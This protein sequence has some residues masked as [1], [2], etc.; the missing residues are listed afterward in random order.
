MAFYKLP[1]PW[2]SNAVLT[3][4]RSSALKNMGRG[5]CIRDATL[6][7]YMDFLECC[8]SVTNLTFHCT[9]YHVIACKHFYRT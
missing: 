4:Q 8:A 6:Y 2:L 9:L 1:V 3:I 7:L 5:N